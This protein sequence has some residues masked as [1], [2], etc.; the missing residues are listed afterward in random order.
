MSLTLRKNNYFRSHGKFQNIGTIL[1]KCQK[2]HCIISWPI[3]LINVSQISYLR[4]TSDWIYL[5]VVSVFKKHLK[6]I[7]EVLLVTE[8]KYSWYVEHNK[9]II[10]RQRSDWRWSWW[11]V[12]QTSCL[13]MSVFSQSLLMH[14]SIIEPSKT[15]LDK[16]L[17]RD[18]SNAM[19]LSESLRC[20]SF[21]AA[22]RDTS[23]LYDELVKQWLFRFIHSNNVFKLWKSSHRR[24]K[25]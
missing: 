15:S 22:G 1:Q 23:Q 10:G 16:R 24:Q 14:S 8:Y 5:T 7:N 6:S 25:P 17:P 12:R 18:L 3:Y 11:N 20:S 9:K 21:G 2:L 4:D 19:K 13:M